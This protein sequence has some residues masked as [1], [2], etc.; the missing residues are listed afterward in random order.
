MSSKFIAFVLLLF[1]SSLT[2]HAQKKAVPSKTEGF[3]KGS[4]IP[5]TKVQKDIWQ[6]HFEGKALKK[7]FVVATE[8]DGYIIL[9]ATVAMQNEYKPSPELTKKLLKTAWN[10]DRV[11]IGLNDEDAII[12]RIDLSLRVTDKREFIECVD[13][14]AAVTD[15]VFESIKPFLSSE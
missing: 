1:F 7:F 12:V 13:Q 3:L 10:T 8:G 11:K 9:F 14:V 5:H 15:Q 4:T 2:A 6:L